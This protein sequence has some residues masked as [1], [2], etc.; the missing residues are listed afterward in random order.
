MNNQS[1]AQAIALVKST[2]GKKVL[3]TYDE[4]DDAEI[5]P[6][7]IYE[8]DQASG[9]G[10][11]PLGRLIEVFGKQSSGK[12]TL[13]WQVLA[14]LQKA[15]K[16]KILYFDYEQSNSMTYLKKLGVPIEE[17]MFGVPDYNTSLE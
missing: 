16:K 12:T 6:T 10:G 8:F 9:V 2:Y 4:H 17:V 1:L 13:T 5:I 7:G 11:I 3:R 15:T 14:A